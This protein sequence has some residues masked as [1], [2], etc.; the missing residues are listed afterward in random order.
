[1]S[2]YTSQLTFAY[3]RLHD[4]TDTTQTLDGQSWSVGY[5]YDYVGGVYTTT[6]PTAVQRVQTVDPINRLDTVRQG[7]GSLIADYAYADLD[8]YM[9]V[10]YANGITNRT[11]YDALRRTTRVSSAVADYRYGYD[12]ASNR[13]YMQRWHETGHPDDVY[14]YDNLYQ[15]T[16]VWYGADATDPGSITSYDS[17]QWYDL[18]SLGNRLE[19]QNDGVS[20]SYQP[21]N[22]QQLTNPMNRYEQVDGTPFTYDLRGNTLN[23][24]TNSYTYDILNRQTT[25]SGP[26]G[27]AEYI[28]DALGRRI[29][30]MVDGVTTH[31]VYDTNYQ[32]IEEHAAD[33]SLL[34]RYTYDDSIDKPLTMERDD[35]TYYYHRDA[36]GS[37]TEVT[38]SSGVLIERYKYDVYGDPTIF[39]SVGNSLSASAIGNTYLFTSRRY[40]SESGN[41]YYRA[42][43][44][45]KTTGRFLVCDMLGTWIDPFNRGNSY[46]Y[47]GNN[48]VNY[49][50]DNGGLTIPNPTDISSVDYWLSIYFYR[51][52]INPFV[53]WPSYVDISYAVDLYRQ[54]SGVQNAVENFKTRVQIETK[55]AAFSSSESDCDEPECNQYKP[56]RIS[57][58]LYVRSIYAF[59]KGYLNGGIDCTICSS[60]KS[61]TA[62]CHLSFSTRDVFTDP[63]D[64]REIHNWPMQLANVGGTPFEFGL[65]WEEN[66]SYSFSG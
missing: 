30:K 18:D 23:D 14:Q 39:D 19:V 66:Y 58:F 65:S 15:L 55:R 63:L 5:D 49:L 6:Y 1:M 24:Q 51:Y 4:V 42:R 54:D 48:P 20:Q 13:T 61:A 46:G 38:D 2:G 53:P 44:L 45:S 28:Y 11:D 47:V 16:Q 17:L 56:G 43:Y 34:A 57:E 31:F 41:Y 59:G 64:L 36:L 3:N 25:M 21:S 62:N 22:G 37:I 33:G 12:A 32:V 27:T 9:T 50:D 35:N 40:D 8:S 26:G 7:D 29:A 52:R 10:A 60:N